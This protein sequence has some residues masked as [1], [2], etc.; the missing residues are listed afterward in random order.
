MIS[1]TGPVVPVD[2]DSAP[3]CVRD[4][5]AHVQRLLTPLGPHWSLDLGDGSSEGILDEDDE[6][7]EDYEDN[8]LEA[9]RDKAQQALADLLPVR[10]PHIVWIGHPTSAGPRRSTRQEG[11]C[12]LA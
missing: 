3:G 6:Y 9:E 5:T 4:A 10:S 1:T 11:P 12:G 8:L 7:D 2:G